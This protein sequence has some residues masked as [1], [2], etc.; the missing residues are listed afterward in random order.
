MMMSS[1]PPIHL[2][3]VLLLGLALVAAPGI[4]AARGSRAATGAEEQRARSRALFDQAE[5]RFHAGQFGEAL[6]LYA[7][8]Y[9]VLPLP[10]FLFNIGQCHRS[11]GSHNRALFYYQGYLRSGGSIPNRE[12]V[13]QLI[14]LSEAALKAEQDAE[15]AR[16]READRSAR[17][18]A[19][20]RAAEAAAARTGAGARLTGDPRREPEARTTGVPVYRRWWFW[21]AIAAGVVAVVITGVGVGIGTRS[22]PPLPAGSLGTIDA[23]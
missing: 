12:L 21:T 4:V 13:E 16:K 10:G 5:S 7:K 1:R 15:R 22:A 11:L 6:D 18:A 17:E 20:L 2:A 8:A 19:T 9:E 23:R 14:A 3:R